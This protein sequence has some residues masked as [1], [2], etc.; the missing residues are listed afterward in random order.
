MFK[1]GGYET[2]EE[3]AGSGFIF[4]FG[5]FPGGLR[6]EERHIRQR[7]QENYGGHGCILRSHGEH[8][9]GQDCGF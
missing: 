1:T 3:D 9:Q 6:R 2:D 4:G 7:R 8:G 5:F